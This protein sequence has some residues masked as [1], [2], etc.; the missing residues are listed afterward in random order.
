MSLPFFEEEM[1][2]RTMKLLLFEI[3]KG[4]YGNRQKTL[5]YRWQMLKESNSQEKGG[6]AFYGRFCSMA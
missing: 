2:Y 5:S 4:N 3:G 6:T 1:S